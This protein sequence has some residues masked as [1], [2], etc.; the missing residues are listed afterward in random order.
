MMKEKSFIG[1]ATYETL[2][3]LYD[4]RNLPIRFYHV[5]IVFEA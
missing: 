3:H 1:L 2:F 5:P 4:F